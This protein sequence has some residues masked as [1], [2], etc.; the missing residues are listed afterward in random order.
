M[1]GV[2]DMGGMHGFG[3]VAVDDDVQFHA[4]W[5][6]LVFGMVRTARSQGIYNVD[7]SRY[8]IER[9]EP[10]EYLES[11]Y[12]ERWLSTLERNLTEKGAVDP[13]EIEA[14]RARARE[15]DDP[16]ALVSERNDP[17]LTKVIRAAF[18]QPAAFDRPGDDSQFDEGESVR[19]RNIHP[20]GHTRCPRYVR[21]AV[22]TVTRAHGPY[23]FPDARADGDERAEP[24]YTVSFSADE[25]WGPD[26]ES[27]DD[28]VSVDLW[29]PYL[30]SVEDG[31]DDV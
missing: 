17:E 3:R 23:V 21:R 20:E 8:G 31:V 15:V 5:E 9:M 1:N 7:E 13:A 12:F 25:L 10:A 28:T 22:G 27:P 11:T 16:A 4:D 2:H 18:E 24:L 19:V 14:A 6:R 29:E 30:Q 26:A